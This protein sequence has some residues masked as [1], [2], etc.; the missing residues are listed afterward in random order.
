P[1]GAVLI[2]GTVA[3]GQVL[4]ATNTLADIDGMG[5]VSY[6]WQADGKVIAGATGKTLLLAQEHVGKAISVVAKYTDGQGTAESKTSE[7]VQL[8]AGLTVTES[9]DG[10]KLVLTLSASDWQPETNSL[11]FTVKYDASLA[12]FSGVVPGS[13]GAY[14]TSVSSSETA[15]QGTAQIK[16]SINNFGD[17]SDFLKIEFEIKGRGGESFAYSLT[18]I[19]LNARNLGTVGDTF[20]LPENSKP[21]GDVLDRKSV[22]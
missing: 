11:G 13:S 2:T 14:S 1:T 5:E 7:A 17:A 3:L 8:N 6:Q 12:S 16:A 15:G 20:I 18:N 10:N 21:T 19:V 9:L 22:V 4:T